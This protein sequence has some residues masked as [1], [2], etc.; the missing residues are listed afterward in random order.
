M[1]L[2]E[3]YDLAREVSQFRDDPLGFVLHCYP[4]GQGELADFRGPDANQREFL[5]SLG[6]EVRER[7]FDGQHAVMPIRMA[8]SSGHGTGKS[9]MGAWIAN[10]ILSTRPW[11]IGTVTA[12][13]ATQLEERTW[14]ALHKWTRLCIT[15]DWWEQQSTGIYIKKELCR[16]HE[17][18]HNWKAVAQTCREEN[19][20]SFAGQHAATSTSWYLFDEASAIPDSIYKVAY[21]GLTDGEPMMFVWGQPERNTGEFHNISFGSLAERWNHRRVDSRTSLF[22]NKKLIAEWERDYG[23]DSDWF[24]VRVLG[25]P[26][27]ADELQYIDFARIQTARK[28][29]VEVLRD[30]PLIA[31]FDVS[32]G[33]AAWNV[34]RFRRG[35]DA[36]TYPPVRITGEQGR[37]RAVLIAKAAEV[38][39]YGVNGQ[40]VAAM[41]VDSAF[42]AAIVERL[43]TM[44]FRN[45]HEVNFG[46]NSPDVHC[47]N[48]RAFMW[49][50]M[51]DWLGKGAVADDERFAQQLGSPGYHINRSN[52]L[53][54][55]AKQEMQKRG[56]ASPDDA[57]ALA[58]TFARAVAPVASNRPRRPIV[59][60]SPWS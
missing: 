4:W 28:R 27:T 30:E 14:S 2:A 57:D 7:A 31:G 10:W 19:A 46:G 16:A 1:K 22:T 23:E 34:I 50:Q 39:R 8:E 21:G 13:T 37:D 43:L 12:G 60:L 56:L 54:I 42:G 47:A 36:R 40:P 52:K 41:F 35:L 18:P 26:P 33:G 45:V 9:A 15:A 55:E 48:Y 53:V 59:H 5:E 3:V 29:P 38:L 49:R 6:R 11:S 58:L 51:K 20:Q 25:L 17:S 32:G 44:G 24:R